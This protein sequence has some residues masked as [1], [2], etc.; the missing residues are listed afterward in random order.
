MRRKIKVC[1]FLLLLGR[2][3]FYPEMEPRDSNKSRVATCRNIKDTTLR[4]EFSTD[5]P[6]VMPFERR[7]RTARR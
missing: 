6:M 3:P 7:A 2:T 5:D 4:N 1:E